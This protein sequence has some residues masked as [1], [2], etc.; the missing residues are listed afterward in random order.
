MIFILRKFSIFKYGFFSC[1]F[2][3]LLFSIPN[4]FTLKVPSFIFSTLSSIFIINFCSPVLIYLPLCSIEFSVT[5]LTIN[6]ILIICESPKTWRF[7]WIFSNHTSIAS[8]I[9]SNLNVL[10]CSEKVLFWI[11]LC[12]YFRL[13]IK[14]SYIYWSLGLKLCLNI[15]TWK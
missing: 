3:I 15:G 4:F 8:N 13:L 9:F 7:V 14:F 1:K 11:E 2:I 12:I 10:D 5:E 6:Q